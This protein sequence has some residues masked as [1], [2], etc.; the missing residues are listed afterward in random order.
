MKPEEYWVI[1]FFCI[2]AF[3]MAFLARLGWNLAGHVR[4]V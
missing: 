1:V 3:A 4:W 2:L